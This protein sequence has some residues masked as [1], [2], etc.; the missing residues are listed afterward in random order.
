MRSLKS[1]STSLRRRRNSRRPNRKSQQLR[2]DPEVSDRE[3]RREKV[4]R[5]E[6]EEGI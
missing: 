6:Q 2:N 4:E 1:P 3:M 5:E